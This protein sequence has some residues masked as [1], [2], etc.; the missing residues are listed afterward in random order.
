MQCVRVFFWQFA[1]ETSLSHRGRCYLTD[2]CVES[3]V[4]L[5]IQSGTLEQS[6]LND[7][8]QDLSQDPQEQSVRH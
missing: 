7:D 4:N 8:V 6:G 1:D 2:D 5:L 3:V